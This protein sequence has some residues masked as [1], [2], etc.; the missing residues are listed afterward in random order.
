MGIDLNDYQTTIKSRVSLSGVGVHSGRPVTVHFSPADADTGIVFQRTD[1][2][3]SGREIRALVSEIGGTDLCT[4][5]GDP[6]GDHVGTVEHL[7]AALSILGIDYVA[8][9]IDGGEVPFMDGSA[10]PFV[11]AFDQAGIETLALKRRFIRILKP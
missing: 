6:E 11:A 8:I 5:L 10:A 3:A 4:A 2:G 1:D 7:M 9:E